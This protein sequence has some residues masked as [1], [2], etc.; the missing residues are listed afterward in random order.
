MGCIR[1]H[2]VLRVNF[3]FKD[4]NKV[5]QNKKLQ[6]KKKSGTQRIQRQNQSFYTVRC[7]CYKMQKRIGDN[8]R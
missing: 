6:K 1:M 5:P 8:L 3:V 7:D 4:T 2:N